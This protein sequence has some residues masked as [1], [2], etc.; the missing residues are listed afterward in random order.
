MGAP[1]VL[2]AVAMGLAAVLAWFEPAHAQVERSYSDFAA[3]RVLDGAGD[4]VVES[5]GSVREYGPEEIEALGAQD[6][7]DLLQMVVGGYVNVGDI[8]PARQ[9]S[10]LRLRGNDPRSIRILVDG[11]PVTNG[12]HG[13]TDLTRITINQVA[14]VR[15]TSGPKSGRYGPNSGGGVVEVLTRRVDDK[16]SAEFS[17]D[18]GN[19]RNLDYGLWFGDTAGVLNYYGAANHDEREGFMVS[20]QFDE[21]EYESD[22]ETGGLRENSDRRRDNFRGRTGLEFDNVIDVYTG[23]S[24]EEDSGGIPRSLDDT[25]R[26]TYRIGYRRRAT[27]QINVLSQPAEWVEVRAIGYVTENSLRTED[28][29]GPET[30][31][32]NLTLEEFEKNLRFGGR[33]LPTFDAGKWSRLRLGA[34]II[35]DQTETWLQ[36]ANHRNRDFTTMRFSAEDDIRPLPVL[37]LSGGASMDTVT[38]DLLESSD[39]IDDQSATNAYGGVLVGPVIGAFFH[40]SGSVASRFPTLDEL[41]GTFG[42]NQLDPESM[43][44]AE[45]G[46]HQE[47]ANNIRPELTLFYTQTQDVIRR[48]FDPTAG[49]YGLLT[50]NGQS[51]VTGV[52]LG[53]TA[54]PWERFYARFDYTFMTARFEVDDNAPDDISDATYVP[55]Q[56]YNALIGYQHESGFGGAVGVTGAGPQE[57]PASILDDSIDPIDGYVLV[58]GRVFYNYR[59]QMVLDLTARN[60]ADMDYATTESYVMPGFFLHGGIRIMF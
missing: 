40:A 16:F 7:A 14:L 3:A 28:Y 35:R 45:V 59:D 44:N 48:V 56:R 17:T 11:V 21:G 5:I 37:A 31:D 22:Q 13:T 18:F 54:Q 42:N 23:G 43:T 1:R 29:L 52:T 55:D 32:E 4:A 39:D 53:L 10:Y 47:F 46:Y 15:V 57:S 50:N 60:A 20:N 2:L 34:E 9:E 8:R 19:A 38:Y 49:E 6:L 36:S 24:Y 41:T 30:E 27:G 33:L 58:H 26:V 51:T 25:G 12:L